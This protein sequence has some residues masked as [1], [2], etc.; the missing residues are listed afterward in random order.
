MMIV[1][2]EELFEEIECQG[3][4]VRGF[5][6]EPGRAWPVALLDGEWVE[7]PSGGMIVKN[8]RYDAEYTY[9][10]CD[11]AETT[12]LLAKA[13]RVEAPYSPRAGE[14]AGVVFIKRPDGGWNRVW[15]DDMDEV[16]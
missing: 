10:P 9:V 16:A 1:T 3:D 4:D 7:L 11:E 6:V 8:S 12:A 15:A 13:S 5:G 2:T 14:N